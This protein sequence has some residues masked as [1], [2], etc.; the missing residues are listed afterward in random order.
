MGLFFSLCS[1]FTF[2]LSFVHVIT[3]HHFSTDRLPLR[4]EDS[5]LQLQT[6]AKRGQ[7]NVR[8]IPPPPPPLP[9]SIDQCKPVSREGVGVREVVVVVVGL[10]LGAGLNA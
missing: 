3:S 1:F 4:G 8:V 5:E 9:S 6:P 2:T 7:H 10:V